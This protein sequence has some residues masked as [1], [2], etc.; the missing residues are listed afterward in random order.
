MTVSLTDN[1]LGVAT[2]SVISL[3]RWVLKSVFGQ[4]LL[5]YFSSPEDAAKKSAGSFLASFI[6]LFILHHMWHL[7]E[8][9][10]YSTV[11][12]SRE[13]CC[14]FTDCISKTSG[15]VQAAALFVAHM[16][17]TDPLSTPIMLQSNKPGQ[18]LPVQPV[19]P[20]VCRN[21]RTTRAYVC[22]CIKSSRRAAS[23]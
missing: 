16:A 11:R 22:R 12:G 19:T 2:F 20:K 13:S 18:H 10:R 14:L 3:V 15:K 8:P 7:I 1:I 5:F 9:H 4:E 17:G 21:A 23:S 6:R